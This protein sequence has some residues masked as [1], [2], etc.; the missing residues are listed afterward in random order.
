[1]AECNC[2]KCQG[3]LV[4]PLCVEIDSKR[5]ENLECYTKS[6]DKSLEELEKKH[7][8]NLKSLSSANTTYNRDQIIQILIDEIITLKSNQSSV[9]SQSFCSNINWTPI[10]NCSNCQLDFCTKLQLLINKVDLLN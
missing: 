8:I 2:I 4:S 6:V 3:E 9:N 7:N 5:G 1:M 10:T